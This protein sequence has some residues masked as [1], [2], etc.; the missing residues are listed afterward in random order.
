MSHTDEQFELIP[1]EE[2][3]GP[4]DVFPSARR[5]GSRESRGRGRPK[6]AKNKKTEQL[7][8][9]WSARGFKDPLMFQG[10]F[11]SSHPADLWKWFVEE[12]AKVDGL[13]LAD[14]II[15]ALKGKLDGIPTIPEIVA[16][17]LKTADHVAPYLHG[18]MP[19]REESDD[20]ERLPVLM[21]DLG[22]DQVN[23]GK[24]LDADEE[25]MS[26]GAQEQSSDDQTQRNQRVS[27]D[28][29]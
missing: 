1:H 23:E 24:Y 20:D 2:E 21:I 22:T 19:V 6:G 10:E 26:I 27:G 25:P 9:M 12:Q 5:S 18:K 7:Q 17:Q 29:E 14:A 15:K 28:D 11:L 8:K 16:M 13:T 3:S 4:D